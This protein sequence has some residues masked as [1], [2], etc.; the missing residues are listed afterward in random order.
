MAV[1]V[2][3][4]KKGSGKSRDLDPNAEMALSNVRPFKSGLARSGGIK[5][6]REVRVFMSGSTF[7]SIII[8]PPDKIRSL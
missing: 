5:T 6:G 7:I 1:R 8:G 3:R 2:E 4:V